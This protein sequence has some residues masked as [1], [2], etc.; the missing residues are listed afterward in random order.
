M[1]K[2]SFSRWWSITQ[3]APMSPRLYTKVVFTKE[4][5][6]RLRLKTF[7]ISTVMVVSKS[8]GFTSMFVHKRQLLLF[9]IGQRASLVPKVVSWWKPCC[10]NKWPAIFY[11]FLWWKMVW[12]CWWCW[13]SLGL[14][15]EVG[16]SWRYCNARPTRDEAG[17]SSWTS[18]PCKN[19]FNIEGGTWPPYQILS[20]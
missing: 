6:R 15:G 10:H 3:P 19:Q 9:S 20:W 4:I 8:F 17:A 11:I 7:F 1:Q 18:S 14:S 16:R 5:K 12:F 13:G 2:T